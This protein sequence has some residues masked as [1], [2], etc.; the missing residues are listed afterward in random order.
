MSAFV[1]PNDVQVERFKRGGKNMLFLAFETFSHPLAHSANAASSL[2]ISNLAAERDSSSSWGSLDRPRGRE[3]TEKVEAVF[4]LGRGRGMGLYCG[5]GR[6]AARVRRSERWGEEER[7]EWTM[8]VFGGSRGR[9]EIREMGRDRESKWGERE[10]REGRTPKSDSTNERSSSSSRRTGSSQIR[11]NQ[12]WSAIRTSRSS[13]EEEEEEEVEWQRN[14][15]EMKRSF[16]S[17]DLRKGWRARAREREGGLGQGLRIKDGGWEDGRKERRRKR[18]E[19][20]EEGSRP[21]S[22]VMAEVDGR[23]RAGTTAVESEQDN[24]ISL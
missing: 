15:K 14:R 21:S 2:P 6:D 24:I 16:V 8:L 5:S 20:K 9:R 12:R 19:K 11:E 1:P 18:G 17:I 23:G 22:S 10:R 7:K 4:F 13:L 3:E